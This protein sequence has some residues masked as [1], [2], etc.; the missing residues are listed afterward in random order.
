[1]TTYE[2]S[3]GLAKEILR[4]AKRGDGPRIKALLEEEESL[5]HARDADGSTALHCAAWKGNADVAALLLDAGADINAQSSNSHYGGTP[6]HAAAHGNQRAVAEVLLARGAD[7]G[8]VSCNGRTPIE[9]TAIHRATG[10][11]NLLRKHEAGG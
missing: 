3:P 4:A 7:T 11:A 5:V 10:V 8:A 6:L 2:G 9:E 1:M